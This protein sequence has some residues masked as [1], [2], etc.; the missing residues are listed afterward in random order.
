MI[1]FYHN[2][3]RL[4]FVVIISFEWINLSEIIGD[5]WS[6]IVLWIRI[7]YRYGKQMMID[8]GKWEK[9]KRVLNTRFDHVCEYY[10][11]YSALSLILQLLDVITLFVIKVV[12]SHLKSIFTSVILYSRVGLK[13]KIHL[14]F[15]PN[16]LFWWNITLLCWIV[17]F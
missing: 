1:F 11:C 16:W 6:S 14:Q 13:N 4:F 10:I 17:F 12:L 7:V 8:V 15:L 9:V 3:Y 2:F 5:S